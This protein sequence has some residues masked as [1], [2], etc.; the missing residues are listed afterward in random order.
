VTNRVNPT[1]YTGQADARPP[2]FGRT[3]ARDRGTVFLQLARGP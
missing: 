1:Q 3:V 2:L